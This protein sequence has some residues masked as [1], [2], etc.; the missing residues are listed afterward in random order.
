[1][2]LLVK[3]SV[4]PIFFLPL[5]ANVLWFATKC[6]AHAPK[7]F[8]F[9]VT[10]SKK[11]ASKNAVNNWQITRIEENGSALV[12]EGIIPI[13]SI[14]RPICEQKTGNM[15]RPINENG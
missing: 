8:F 6:S 3:L 1:M 11:R 14:D 4:V 13:K 2:N 5:M 15:L 7:S 10:H 9:C 12:G